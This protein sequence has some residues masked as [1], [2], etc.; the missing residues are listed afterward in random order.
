M[1]RTKNHCLQDKAP[2][3]T[4]SFLTNNT[5]R[6]TVRCGILVKGLTCERRSSLKEAS[7]RSVV[8][9]LVMT[10]PTKEINWK[11][12]YIL[13][14]VMVKAV[15]IIQ[16]SHLLY[17]HQAPNHNIWSFGTC[18]TVLNK[19]FLKKSVFICSNTCTSIQMET[20]STL[21]SLQYSEKMALV[22]T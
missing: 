19:C 21:V 10:G 8:I 5:P 17:Y 9:N 13:H 15:F 16:A 4:S 11:E 6:K 18:S 12:K 14:L 20:S 2:K 3:V 1:C 7:S 22:V